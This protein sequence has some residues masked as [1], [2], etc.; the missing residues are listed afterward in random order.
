MATLVCFVAGQVGQNVHAGTADLIALSNPVKHSIM[1]MSVCNHSRII[2]CCSDKYG[3][4][5][6]DYPPEL[7][8]IIDSIQRMASRLEDSVVRK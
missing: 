2:C 4:Q 1:R 7:D 5:Y 3:I 6:V 8:K